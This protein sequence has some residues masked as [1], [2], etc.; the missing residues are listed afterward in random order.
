ML[1]LRQ[2]LGDDLREQLPG[3]LLDA[4]GADHERLI[5]LAYGGELA[6]DGANLLRRRHHQQEVAGGNLAELGGR[7]DRRVERDARQ[8]ERV[9]VRLVDLGDGLGLVGPQDARR[10]RPG[11]RSRQAPSPRRLR[12][13]CRRFAKPCPGRH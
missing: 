4:L 7:L 8:I 9:P 5:R 1:H 13:Q 10:G 2:H 12:R 11:A 6:A 3:R